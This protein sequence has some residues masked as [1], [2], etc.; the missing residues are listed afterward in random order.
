ME[1]EPVPPGTL[2][3]EMNEEETTQHSYDLWATLDFDSFAWSGFSKFTLRVSTPANVSY[4]KLFFVYLISAPAYST[5]WTASWM[6]SSRQ[7]YRLRPGR[8]QSMRVT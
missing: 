1:L 8:Y 6:Y 4:S 3:Q 5:Q 7:L 2:H